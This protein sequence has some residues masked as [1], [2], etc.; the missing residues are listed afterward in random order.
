MKKNIFLQIAP[1]VIMGFAFMLFV[2]SDR[3]WAQAQQPQIRQS[4]ER[5]FEEYR[6]AIKES[7]QVDI[8]NFKDRT[9][10]RFGGRKSHHQLRFRTAARRDKM[11]AAAYHAITCW[12]LNWRWII[13]RVFPIIIRALPGWNGNAVPKSLWEM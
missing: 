6:T 9:N 12:L 8:K 4:V 1:I 5:K 3:T 2:K 10:G 7:H 13:L 11:G